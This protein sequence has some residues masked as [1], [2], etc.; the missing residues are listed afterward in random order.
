MLMAW[1]VHAARL[2]DIQTIVN[3]CPSSS[4]PNRATTPTMSAQIPLRIARSPA[5]PLR[6]RCLFQR[7]IA[8]STPRCI[9]ATAAR[10]FSST[11]AR[12]RDKVRLVDPRMQVAAVEYSMAGRQAPGVRNKGEEPS[13]M[14]DDIGILQGTVI[15]APFSKLPRPTSWE[16]YSY[17]WTVVKSKASALYTRAHFKRCLQKTGIASY[18]P[19]D[20]LKQ[21]ELKNKAKELYKQYY[22]S[23][24]AYVSDAFA[25]P[26]RPSQYTL[27]SLQSRCRS[28]RQHLPHCPLSLLAHADPRPRCRET[29]VGTCEVQVRPHRLAPLHPARKREPRHL[30]PAVHRAPRIRAAAVRSVDLAFF[31]CAKTH[32]SPYVDAQVCAS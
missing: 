28:H 23:L 22:E 11:P 14:A 29:V 27:T 9:A 7:P 2:S 15:R 1:S 25:L 30:V 26:M 8:P 18:L 21:Q 5:H 32:T 20:L 13:G 3:F 24:T 6:H 31:C 17:F 4:R 19:V 10:A 16:F 12:L